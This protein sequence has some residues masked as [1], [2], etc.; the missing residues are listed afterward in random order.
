[1]QPILKKLDE[2]Y[3]FVCLWPTL[4]LPLSLAE[5]SEGIA[6]VG[7]FVIFLAVIADISLLLAFLSVSYDVGRVQVGARPSALRL[8]GSSFLK[9]FVVPI[10][11][12]IACVITFVQ[13]PSVEPARLVL[14]LF[15][16]TIATGSGAVLGLCSFFLGYLGRS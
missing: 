10:G 16:W 13:G 3:W 5:N 12:F 8:I 11:V 7:K 2:R 4:L 1:M 15:L 9:L 14:F 6:S